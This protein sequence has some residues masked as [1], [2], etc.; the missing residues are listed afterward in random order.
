MLDYLH[1]RASSGLH[2]EHLSL[3]LFV[4]PVRGYLSIAK[5]TPSFDSDALKVRDSSESC[6]NTSRTVLV[7]VSSAMLAL[8]P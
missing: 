5:K 6:P 3:G 8:L 2:V 1:G 7:A 4:L